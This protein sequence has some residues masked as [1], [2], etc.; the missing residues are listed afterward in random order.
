MGEHALW[1]MQRLKDDQARQRRGKTKTET[2]RRLRGRS[3]PD[4]ALNRNT[5]NPC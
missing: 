4:L 3:C 1:K 2:E 5:D